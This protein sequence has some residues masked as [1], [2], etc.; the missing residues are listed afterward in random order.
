MAAGGKVKPTVAPNPDDVALLISKLRGRGFPHY[1]LSDDERLKD[2]STFLAYD[3]SALIADGVV[4]QTL[5][6]MGLLW[7]YFPHHWA[8]KCGKM[9]TPLDIWEDD[10][11]FHRAIL[12]RIKWGGY[13]IAGDGTPNMTPAQVRKAI[14]TASGTQRVSNFRPTAAAAIYDRFARGVVWDMSCGFGGRLLGAIA[15]DRVTGYI[16]TD[17]SAKTMV[18]LRQIAEDFG[19][20]KAIELHQI[21]SEEFTPTAGS[22]SLCFTS[23]P[24]FNTEAYAN[25]ETQSAVRFK[26]ASAWRDGFLRQTLRN[27]YQALEEGGHMVINI[28][29]VKSYPELVFDTEALALHIGFRQLD[30][31]RLALSSMNKG[32]FKFEPILVFVKEGK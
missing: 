8:I 1:E 20:N 29:D 15:S 3:R 21:G 11:L 32:G 22:V 28:A 2:F 16:G 23:P 18:G 14:R 24:Y 9:L 7:S 30:T 13:D 4:W 6:A 31:L 10:A 26:T 19:G 12:S 25:E 27:C 5:H 17:P